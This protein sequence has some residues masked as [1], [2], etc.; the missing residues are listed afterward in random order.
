MRT[1][2]AAGLGFILREAERRGLD[3]QSWMRSAGIAPEDVGDPE[4]RVPI[5]ASDRLSVALIRATGDRDVAFD[6]VLHAPAGQR[7]LFHYLTITSTDL[8]DY[9]ALNRDYARL[10]GDG[11]GLGLDPLPGAPG[12]VRVTVQTPGANERPADAV[13]FAV[14][15]WLA[16]LTLR[17]RFLTRD[18]FRPCRVVMGFGPARNRGAGQKVFGIE[19]E[20]GGDGHFMD[21]PAAAF[22]LPFPEGDANLRELLRARADSLMQRLPSTGELPELVRERVLN[23]LSRGALSLEAVAAALGMGGRTLQRRLGEE[24]KT[25]REVVDECRKEL[26]MRYLAETS[27]SVAEVAER[28]GFETQGALTKRFKRWTGMTPRDHRRTRGRT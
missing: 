3:S 28:L 2:S 4:R 27:M 22:E 23:G 21:V 16:G 25:Y 14:Q 1:V 24:G 9:L 13:R 6:A 15:A 17:A 18:R 5:S 11:V 10:L 7:A 8:R 26:A 19:P 20:Y 12:G